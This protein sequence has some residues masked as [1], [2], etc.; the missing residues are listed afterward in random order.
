MLQYVRFQV[1]LTRLPVFSA[2]EVSMNPYTGPLNVAA[3]AGEQDVAGRPSL[4]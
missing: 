2:Y 3:P 1:K 4:W